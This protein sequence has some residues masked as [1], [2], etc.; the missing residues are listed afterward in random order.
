[1][2]PFI[3]TQ[4]TGTPKTS[5]AYHPEH[6]LQLLRA[7]LGCS[8]TLVLFSSF[9][10]AQPFLAGKTY[11]SANEYIAY[12]SGNMP[13]IRSV[14]HG[15]LL[16]PSSIPD[17]SCAGYVPVMNANT[18]DLGRY[19]VDERVRLSGRPCIPHLISNRLRRTILDANHLKC[20]FSGVRDRDLSLRIF[21]ESTVGTLLKYLKT[22]SF[23]KE[24]FSCLKLRTGPIEPRSLPFEAYPNPAFGTVTL[25]LSEAG[26]IHLYRTNGQRNSSIN[27]V[28]S[29]THRLTLL[30][31]SDW[32]WLQN[33]TERGGGA[34]MKMLNLCS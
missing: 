31:E 17:R 29:G 9:L 14:A 16:E 3:F 26:I 30:P 34:F 28:Q 27:V 4:G 10:W 32:T 25:H 22:H 5:A 12:L 1:M 11:F 19:L 21:A 6:F 15:G 2:I 8:I 24:R 33:P 23:Q 13:L 20:P 18:Q 7:I